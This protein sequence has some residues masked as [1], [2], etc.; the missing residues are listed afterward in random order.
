MAVA[1]VST[2]AELFSW[3]GSDNLTIPLGAAFT[4]LLLR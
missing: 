2:L 1:V 4:L 3:R